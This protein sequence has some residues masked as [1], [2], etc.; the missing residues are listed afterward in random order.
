MIFLVSR[1]ELEFCARL[2]ICL[3][4][5]IVGLEGSIF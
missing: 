2:I 4:W 5:G 1:G 3:L